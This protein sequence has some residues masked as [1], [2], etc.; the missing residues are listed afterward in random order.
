MQL[1]CRRE[2]NHVCVYAGLDLCLLFR[3]YKPSR[4]YDEKSNEASHYVFIAE[5]SEV[6]THGVYCIYSM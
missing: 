5:L 3:I 1:D 2:R 6:C 4:V